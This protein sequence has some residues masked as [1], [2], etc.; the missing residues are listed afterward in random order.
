[1][2]R[3]FQSNGLS[4]KTI[5]LVNSLTETLNEF[6]SFDKKLNRLDLD[7]LDFHPYQ[8]RCD[9]FDRTVRGLCF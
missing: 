9:P 4:E 3:E 7:L 6:F 8:S 5:S 2:T 1:M